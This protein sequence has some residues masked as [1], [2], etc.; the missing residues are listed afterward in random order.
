MGKSR[1]MSKAEYLLAQF[2]CHKVESAQ[3]A[4]SAITSHHQHSLGSSK[5]KAYAYLEHY[6]NGDEDANLPLLD[7][8]EQQFDI[9]KAA[10]QS[11][12]GV[13]RKIEP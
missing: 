2:E 3:M 11:L 5:Q 12:G 13:Q 4:H 9:Y 1:E 8:I 6:R 10:C 7:V